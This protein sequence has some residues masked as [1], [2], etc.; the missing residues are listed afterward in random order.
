MWLA[1]G[2][3]VNLF[4]PVTVILEFGRSLQAVRVDW[5]ITVTWYQQA[6]N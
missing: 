6:T 5:S 4:I 2:E 1:W 3:V